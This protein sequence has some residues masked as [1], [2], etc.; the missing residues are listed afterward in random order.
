MMDQ[1]D[2]ARLVRENRQLKRTLHALL[3]ELDADPGV[4]IDVAAVRAD[5]PPVVS[6][7]EG[8]DPP[9]D[10]DGFASKDEWLAAQR[11]SE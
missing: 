11:D 3:D 6:E 2:Y 4:G 9:W 7:S 5:L 10:R 8:I 1:H